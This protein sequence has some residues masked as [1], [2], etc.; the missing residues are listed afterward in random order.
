MD[1]RK[2]SAILV[3]FDYPDMTMSLIVRERVFVNCGMEAIYIPSMLLA[4]LIV[5]DRPFSSYLSSMGGWRW[6]TFLKTCAAAFVIVGIP[7]AIHL[8]LSGNTGDVRFTSGGLILLVLLM[9]LLCIAEELF[10]RGY[11]MQTVSRSGLCIYQRY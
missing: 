5:K 9:P 2:R 8:L 11:V 1:A 4:A 10:Y 6:K 7:T 3:A